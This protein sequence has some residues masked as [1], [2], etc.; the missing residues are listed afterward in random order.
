MLFEFC[1]EFLEGAAYR[2]DESVV[3][4]ILILLCQSDL[5]VLVIF[6]TRC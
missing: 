4:T 3:C 2:L 6:V 5:F 1:S